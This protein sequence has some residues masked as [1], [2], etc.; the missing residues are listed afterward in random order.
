[1]AAASADD[2]R[3]LGDV[4]DAFLLGDALLVAPAVRPGTTSRTVPLPSG[5]WVSPWGDEVA[6]GPD[7]LARVPAPLPRV[8]LL[9]RAGSVVPFDDG[10]RQP[11]GCCAFDTDAHGRP[12]AGPDRLREP[13]SRDH[14]PRRLAFH[15][16]PTGRLAMADG[17]ADLSGGWAAGTAI[18]DAGDGDG[19]CRVDRLT[20][21]GVASGE[22]ATC[23]WERDGDHPPPD[24]VRVVLHGWT[25]AAAEVDGRPVAVSGGTVDVPVFAEL[26]LHG[27]L[28]VAGP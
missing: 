8:P 17:P 9:V 16:W 5:G 2:L 7:R 28:P 3:R 1:M 21:S 24:R 22:T 19:P 26:R 25:A 15:C 23:R 27:L 14:A 12:P 13:V 18:D 20:L 10:W 11:Q 6:S 4:D